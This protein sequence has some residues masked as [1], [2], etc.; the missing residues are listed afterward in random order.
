MQT[1]DPAKTQIFAKPSNAEQQTKSGLFI[2]DG[3]QERPQTAEVINVGG[4]VKQFKSKD[5]IVYKMFTTTELKLNGEEYILIDEADVLG[6][7]LDAVEE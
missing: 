2:P 5:I 6:R 4:G 3:A 1:I 7:V